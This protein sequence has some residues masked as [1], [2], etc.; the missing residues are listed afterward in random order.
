M[1]IASRRVR[2]VQFSRQRG[3]HFGERLCRRDQQAHRT[4]GATPPL[5]RVRS[6][7]KKLVRPRSWWTSSH[8]AKRVLQETGNH[9][10]NFCRTRPIAIRTTNDPH[11]TARN[12]LESR[13]SHW[14]LPPGERSKTKRR[15]CSR[16]FRCG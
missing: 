2:A 3:F 7:S 5:G 6:C 13:V 10:G 12:E 1:P 11:L 14:S 16:R 15:L 4:C 8:G 9:A